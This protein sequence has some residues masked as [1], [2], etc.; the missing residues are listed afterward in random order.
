MRQRFTPFT[1]ATIFW[2]VFVAAA[3]WLTRGP[4]DLDT[5]SAMRLAQVRDLLHGQSWFDTTQW[6]M[7]TPYGLTTHWSRLADAPLALLM[8][9]SERFALTAWPLALFFAA[10]FLLARIANALGG[11]GAMLATLILAVLTPQ[12]F[13]DFLPGSID[14]HNLQLVLMLATLWGLVEQRPRLTA[15]AVALGLGVG[16]ESLPYAV[17][18]LAAAA[19]WLRDAPQ[20]AR[21][22]GITLAIIAL[23]LLFATTASAYRTAPVC[24]TYSL[25]YAVLLAAGGA[26]LVAISVLKNY[27]LWSLGVLAIGLLA[28]AAYLNPGCFAGPYGGM[29]ARMHAIFLSRINEARPVWQFASF[30]PSETVAGYGYAAFALALCFLAPK[31]RAR[32]LVSAFA[33]AAL[34]VATFQIRAVPFAI[35]FALPG[36]AAALTRRIRNPVFLTAAILLCGGGCF[37]LLGAMLEGGNHLT[38][39]IKAFERQEACGD[40]SAMTVLAHL[41][42]GRVAAFVDQGPAILAYT[43][44]SAIAGPYHRDAAGILDTYAI[45]A[46][47]A[48][49]AILA[50]R[51]ITYVM[52]CKNAPDWDFYRARGGLIAQLAA[53]HVPDWLVPLQAGVVALY[54][55]KN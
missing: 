15:I 42:P 44:D 12:I 5:D 10:L 30:A 47:N 24:D 52:T 29:D 46:G 3:L 25:F 34:L 50:R 22:F 16:L 7:N 45:F 1:L 43:K 20:R 40:R 31:A 13:H 33:A 14:H 21:A 54:R 38:A 17:V 6:R 36:M 4:I 55:V 8:L 41:P 2:T 53:G 9:V 28:L 11:K 48:P 19:L 39:R 32:T 37:S 35:L 26:G 27:R 51:G 18:A 23:A 49:R